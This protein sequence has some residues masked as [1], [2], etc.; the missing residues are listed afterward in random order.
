MCALLGELSMSSAQIE[1]SKKI[2]AQITLNQSYAIYYTCSRILSTHSLF[3][4]NSSA[5]FQL[6]AKAP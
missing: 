3:Q 1:M 5:R 2:L 6:H 4:L